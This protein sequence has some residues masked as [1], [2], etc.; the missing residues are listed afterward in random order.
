MNWSTESEPAKDDSAPGS[1][2]V[3]PGVVESRR[4]IVSAPLAAVAAVALGKLGVAQEPATNESGQIDFDQLFQECAALAQ[5]ANRDP[6]LN[7]DAHLYRI[8]AVAARLK[9]KSVP[10][11]KTGRFAGLNPPVNF[12]PV[13]IALP[14]AIILWRLDPWAVLPPHNH[15]PADVLSICLSGEARVRHF[16]TVGEPPE[17]GSQKTFL[18]RETRNIL[19]TPGRMSGLTQTRDNIHTFH[20]G[21]HGATGIDINSVLPGKKDFSFLQFADK[22]VDIE[23]RTYEAVWTKIG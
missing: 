20:A 21:E 11:A 19:L 16:D 9:L 4:L 14:L 23:K 3:A 2:Q 17:Y 12:G 22:P 8:A 7:E 15:N 18:V 13:R 1:N 10:E 5:R 6:G